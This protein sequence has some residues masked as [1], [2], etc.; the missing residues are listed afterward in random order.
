MLPYQLLQEVYGGTVGLRWLLVGYY[1]RE[2]SAVHLLGNQLAVSI[3]TM[4]VG[5][6]DHPGLGVARVALDSFDIALAQFQLQGCTAV[7]QTVK[8][9]RVQKIFLD[10][11]VEHLVDDALL[12]GP[13]VDLGDY[14]IIVPVFVPQYGLVL[15]LLGLGGAQFVNDGLGQTDCAVAALRL[16]C[17]Q[18]KASGGFL[19]HDLGKLED[20]RA[21]VDLLQCCYALIGAAAKLTVHLQMCLASSG[22]GA[23]NVDVGPL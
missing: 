10:Q 13:S 4:S 9:H 11:L 1:L 8:D 20:D 2:K 17:F 21:A 12:I 16:G 7:P 22:V 6:C 14:Q 18:H 23:V 19:R 3:K 5:V 15:L